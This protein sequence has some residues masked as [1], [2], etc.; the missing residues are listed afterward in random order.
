MISNRAIQQHAPA[1][2]VQQAG[3]MPGP[4]AVSFTDNRPQA[5]MQ[6]KQ[7]LSMKAQPVQRAIKKM[8]EDEDAFETFYSLHALGGDKE[9]DKDK[10]DEEDDKFISTADKATISEGVFSLTKA[11][12]AVQCNCFGWAL[13][14]DRDT[15]DKGK[16]Y[17]WKEDHADEYNF[18]APGEDAD[19]I[20]WG[21]KEGAGEDN[22][23]VLHAS[24]KLTHSQLKA[25]SG[26]YK[27]LIVTQK[28][29]TDNEIPNP[30]WSSAGGMGF[31]IMVHPRTW[32]E[33]GSFGVALKGMKKK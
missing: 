5:A 19:I 27:G 20:L 22:W 33:G 30:S 17:N 14:E 3:G 28:E 31:G 32:Y 21:D 11:T 12:G 24:V 18:V 16:I 2:G 10:L 25:R 4:L 26:Q 8:S 13:G 9:Y 15:G 7:I 6:M 29:L 23:D 1:T